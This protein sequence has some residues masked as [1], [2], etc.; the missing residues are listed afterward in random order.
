MEKQTTQEVYLNYSAS[1]DP[2]GGFGRGVQWGEGGRQA[3]RLCAL[4]H[5]ARCWAQTHATARGVALLRSRVAHALQYPHEQH[6][7]RQLLDL[8]VH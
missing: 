5:A 4:T 7:W 3:A 1:V 6:V 2:G 8:H